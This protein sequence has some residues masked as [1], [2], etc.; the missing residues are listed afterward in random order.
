ML[1]Y[2]VIECLFSWHYIK[3]FISL[4]WKFYFI[5][6]NHNHFIL[7]KYNNNS[8]DVGMESCNVSHSTYLL[9]FTLAI[10]TVQKIRN[11]FLFSDKSCST[12]DPSWSSSNSTP[13]PHQQP[14]H[15][16]GEGWQV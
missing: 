3:L 15:H 4:C 6:Y 12:E 5:N 16:S 13:H 14:P 1:F 10:C 7:N 2:W 11:I 9:L 8:L